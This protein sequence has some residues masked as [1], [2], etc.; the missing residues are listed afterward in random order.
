MAQ[1]VQPKKEEIVV[2]RHTFE[3]LVIFEV[4]GQELD[5]MERETSSVSEDFSFALAGLSIGVTIASVLATVTIQ[6][7]R[8]FNS[9]LIV[10]VI[11][12]IVTLYCGFRWL[13][14]RRGFKRVTQQIKS[15]RSPLGEQGK[16]IELEALTSE[17]QQR[18]SEK[19]Q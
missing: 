3:A 12:F 7:E 9:F 18:P 2:E 1:S 17:P 10:M 14:A 19:P 4:T 6:S 5:Q 11:G 15:R 16:E 8:V 13:R